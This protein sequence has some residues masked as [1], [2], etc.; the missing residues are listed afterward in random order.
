VSIEKALAPT[1]PVMSASIFLSMIRLAAWT[2]A[3]LEAEV[4][5][6]LTLSNSI[7]SV[8]TMTK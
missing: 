1:L 6:F 7:E 5:V 2:P 8:S 3:P 4:V